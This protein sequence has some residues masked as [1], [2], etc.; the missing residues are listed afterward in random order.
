ML[1]FHE[2]MRVSIQHNAQIWQTLDS[3]YQLDR[4]LIKCNRKFLFIMTHCSLKCVDSRLFV[5]ARK[6]EG[7]GGI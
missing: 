4:C 7:D 5:G 1:C 2:I 6:K 3:I